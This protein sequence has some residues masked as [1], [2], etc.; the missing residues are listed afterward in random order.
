MRF[1]ELREYYEAED[2]S[3]NTL[4]I[5]DTRRAKIALGRD[6]SFNKNC[7]SGVAPLP[8]IDSSIESLV[9][10]PVGSN[11]VIGGHHQLYILK[12]RKNYSTGF[13]SRKK[14]K[15]CNKRP[16]RIAPTRAPGTCSLNAI[17]VEL[18]TLLKTF[19]T[20]MNIFGLRLGLSD[21]TLHASVLV[22][23]LTVLV[24]TVK[25]LVATKTS[26]GTQSKNC[27]GA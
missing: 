26:Q 18:R 14:E 22:L 27:T 20:G 7:C 3:I 6:K 2:D 10:S 11:G 12:S 17:Q 8:P 9:R 15:K 23:S 13:G 4:K 24:L 19:V 5:D 1:Q 16:T 25:G 21:T